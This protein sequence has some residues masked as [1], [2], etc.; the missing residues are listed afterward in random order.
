MEY[1]YVYET[2]NF[3]VEAPTLPHVSREEGGHLRI[4]PKDYYENRCELPPNKAIEIMRL[5]MIIG[6]ALKEAMNIRGVP[7]IRINYH[8]MGNW[9]YKTN[10]KPFFHIHI[11]GRAENAVIQIWPEAVQLPDRASGFYDNFKPLNNEDIEEIKKQILITEKKEKYD[12]SK[13][14]WSDA[15]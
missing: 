7:I 11:Y 12:Y 14:I 4:K 3:I 13:W 1:I 2:D 8:D 5:T 10:K 6:E 15:V 9:A